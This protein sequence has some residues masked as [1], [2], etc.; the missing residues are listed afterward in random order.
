LLHQSRA[1][2]PGHVRILHHG[3]SIR[4]PPTKKRIEGKRKRAG[5]GSKEAEIHIGATSVSINVLRVSLNH[6][7][8]SPPNFARHA[9]RSTDRSPNRPNYSDIYC[10]TPP[11][12]RSRI[13]F[14]RETVREAR[15][16]GRGGGLSIHFCARRCATY[17]MFFSFPPPLPPTSPSLPPLPL[18]PP[19]FSSLFF[20]Q[21]HVAARCS[22]SSRVSRIRSTI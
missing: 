11:R 10:R 20:A 3:A 19:L 9:A 21:F 4:D 15:W 2:T 6:Q 7:D 13:L 14:P 1:A 12:S 8:H 22:K 5:G 16:G 18:S 17:R